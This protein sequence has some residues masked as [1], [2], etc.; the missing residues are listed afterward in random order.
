MK[1]SSAIFNINMHKNTTNNR[2]LNQ[3][4]K[5][6]V[7]IETPK[8]GNDFSIEQVTVTMLVKDQ[9]TNKIQEIAGDWTPTS[10]LNL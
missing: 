2:L 9:H 7:K 10:T 4:E 1:S 8:P 5:A 3:L 6:I